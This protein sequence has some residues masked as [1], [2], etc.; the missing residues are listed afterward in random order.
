MK[1]IA[2]KMLQIQNTYEPLTDHRLTQEKLKFDREMYKIKS[3]KKKSML[4]NY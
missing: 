4:K 2:Q 1:L 3:L